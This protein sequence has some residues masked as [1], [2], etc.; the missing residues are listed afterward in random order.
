MAFPK[1]QCGHSWI[2]ICIFIN[3]V[4][5]KEKHIFR[6]V[7]CKFWIEDQLNDG[8]IS[9]SNGFESLKD[10]QNYFNEV[11]MNL[12]YR[13]INVSES[14]ILAYFLENMTNRLK[15]DHSMENSTRIRS[16][17]DVIGDMD[18][19]ANIILHKKYP[20]LENRE[21]QSQPRLQ[22]LINRSPL[23]NLSPN[24]SKNFF[25]TILAST[26]LSVLVFSLIGITTSFSLIFVATN[27]N[28][29]NSS[30]VYLDGS[31]TPPM[32]SIL[33]QPIIMLYWGILI[34]IQSFINLILFYLEPLRQKLENLSSR[35]IQFKSF[36][37][38]NFLSFTL[39]SLLEIL[40]SIVSFGGNPINGLNFGVDVLPSFLSG[41]LLNL[42]SLLISIKLTRGLPSGSE[43]FVKKK[44]IIRIFYN[45]F[46]IAYLFATMAMIFIFGSVSQQISTTNIDFNNTLILFSNAMAWLSIFS[47]F[48][49]LF[50][51]VLIYFTRFLQIPDYNSWFTFMLRIFIIQVILASIYCG[52]TYF[53]YNRYLGLYPNQPGFID[54]SY[55]NIYNGYLEFLIP[56]GLFMGILMLNKVKG[57]NP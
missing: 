4:N 43:S 57:N 26:W 54:F 53:M 31:L 17:N 11:V 46:R 2:P 30:Y 45:I 24:F 49:T 6:S 56:Q 38:L 40:G 23:K 14:E 41:F 27:P 42:A 9:K 50:L 37:Y 29:F 35:I 16:I 52:F 32:T 33:E 51:V 48:Q 8:E 5:K 18:E 39:Y 12:R 28:G 20:L 36:M 47:L 22:R 44:S 34:F 10:F 15:I 55:A 13:G 21:F 3:L 25:F 1:V 19:L 7:E